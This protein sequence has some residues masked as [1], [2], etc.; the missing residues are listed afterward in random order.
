MVSSR[1]IKRQRYYAKN[2]RTA[3][4]LIP[5]ATKQGQD[6]GTKNGASARQKL[7]F[8]EKRRPKTHHDGSWFVAKGGIVCTYVSRKEDPVV[9]DVVS[10]AGGR[11][12]TIGVDPLC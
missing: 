5:R 8:D 9:L 7:C 4:Q 6:R 11:T 12:T 1:G 10:D 2:Q 3:G